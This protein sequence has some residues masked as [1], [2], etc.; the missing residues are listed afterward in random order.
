MH[1]RDGSTFMGCEVLTVEEVAVESGDKVFRYKIMYPFPG[2]TE[3]MLTIVTNRSGKN[4]LK[5]GD[6]GHMVVEIGAYK[7]YPQ[8]SF[9]SF[10]SIK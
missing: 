2:T 1:K 5:Q 3:P 6:K 10:Q 9:V 8:Y 4:G 7:D